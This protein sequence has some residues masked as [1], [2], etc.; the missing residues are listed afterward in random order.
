MK[1]MGFILI[2]C[3]FVCAS[4]FYVKANTDKATSKA[5]VIFT[6]DPRKPK[7]GTDDRSGTFPTK[8]PPKKLPKTGDTTD[9]YLV[10]LGFGFILIAK[11]GYF[12]EVRKEIR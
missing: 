2:C 7:T 12:K 10:L 1:K 8:V 9:F 5:G 3:L 11:K 6:H 4:P